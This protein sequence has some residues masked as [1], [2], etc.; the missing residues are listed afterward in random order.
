[1]N[2]KNLLIFIVSFLFFCSNGC[3]QLNR[4]ESKFLANESVL[5]YLNL[6]QT[7][8][9]LTDSAWISIAS[10]VLE[11]S[12]TKLERDSSLI[13]LANLF[14]TMGGYYFQS[15]PPTGRIFYNSAIQ[16]RKAFYHTE[17]QHDI[18]R[19]VFN[20]G[21]CFFNEKDFVNANFYFDSLIMHRKQ[22][23]RQ[24]I[25]KVYAE[26]T[27]C[28][29]QLNEIQSAFKLAMTAMQEMELEFDTV[30][31]VTAFD[32]NLDSQFL[33]YI[34]LLSS[35][36]DA[37]SS[38]D[39]DN[40]AILAISRGIKICIQLEKGIDFYN[41]IGRL[42]MLLGISFLNRH[43]SKQSRGQIGIDLKY[44]ERHLLNAEENF[45]KT[46]N[47]EYLIYIWINLSSLYESKKQYE[48]GAEYAKK[49]SD[50]IT[51]QRP[52]LSD[53]LYDLNIN[54][55]TNLYRQG[56]INEALEAYTNSIQFL[57]SSAT[58]NVL[59]NLTAFKKRTQSSLIL[60]GSIGR[61]RLR[62]AQ[63]SLEL[64]PYANAAY[65]TL[66][67]LINDLRAN[68]INDDAKMLL[69][70]QSQ[71]WLPDA[72]EDIKQLYYLSNDSFYLEQAFKIAEQGKAF[73]L[74]EASR[75]KN[76]SGLLSKDL[77]KDQE[78][79]NQIELKAASGSDSLKQMAEQKKMAFL[80]KLKKDA[81]E[82]FALKYKGPETNV[83]DIQKELIDS[84]QAILQYF[85]QEDRLNVFVLTKDLFAL[86]TIPIRKG[87]LYALIDQFYANINPENEQGTVDPLKIKNFISAS[88]ALYQNLLGKTI[89]QHQLPERLIII[90]DGRLNELSF[91]ALLCKVDGAKDDLILQAKN[92]NYLV[93]NKTIS[94][95]FSVSLLHEMMQSSTESKLENKLSLFAPVFQ[96]ESTLLPFMRNQ[97][98]EIK[99]IQAEVS[100]TSLNAES[101]KEEF[102]E[103][104]QKY[105]YLHLCAHGFVSQN[106]DQ[107][108]VAFRQNSTSPDTSQF[109]YLKEL[110]HHKL[111]QDLITLTACETA[112]GELKAGE[113]NISMARGFAYAG[114]KAF[115]T[116]LWKIQT[117]GAAQ[118]IPSFYKYFLKDHLPKDVAL[119]QSKRDFL[120]SG[121]GVYPE[122]WAGMILIGNTAAASVETGSN[123]A[124]LGYF[125]IGI[126]V[127]FLFWVYKRK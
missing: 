20:L 95:C 108:F 117:N 17:A 109:F 2:I 100:S 48:F 69:A 116:T 119:T 41:R 102:L 87:D 11:L 53:E 50:L 8:S 56:K 79:L 13:Q 120:A 105:K 42:N 22:V 6:I 70:K 124:W 57:D 80:S 51:S 89:Q 65:D 63:D 99:S 61:A 34:N 92:H 106:P 121:K 39:R 66:F 81:P 94:Y 85:V 78:E 28:Q 45:N 52:D 125:G 62:L 111:N 31:N 40:V 67:A 59:P 24:F 26:K 12:P 16:L 75:L 44:A 98:A 4:T 68:L 23:N 73:A 123:F 27:K 47:L 112:V 83:Q 25:Y 58:K 46:N 82:Y 118:I 115:I 35:F 43:K 9:T 122:N 32:Q 88:N 114:V 107:S 60:L 5:Q 30:K 126:L 113:G 104:S 72:F 19:A 18:H 64:L 91:D 33:T 49:A 3:Q 103:A 71:E 21:M 76:A 1:M 96:K 86:D 93:Q 54:L 7:D 55:G 36:S 37:C 29:L 127:F 15:D 14:H 101:T 97:D 10:K 84:N 110:Y 38:L 90:P 74:L 77:Q